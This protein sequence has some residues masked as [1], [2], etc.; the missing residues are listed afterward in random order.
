[1]MDA[2]DIMD[3]LT[4]ALCMAGGMPI[5]IRTLRDMTAEELLLFL[6]PNHV[7]FTYR[8]PPE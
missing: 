7:R 2:L 6:A 8:K 4:T 3:S 5:G 1:M